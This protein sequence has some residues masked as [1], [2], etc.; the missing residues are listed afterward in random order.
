MRPE[1]LK[2]LLE[3]VAA[4]RVSP[5]GA[6]RRLAHWPYEDLGFSKVDHHRQERQGFPEVVYAPGKTAPQLVAIAR[7]LFRRSAA[8][9][10]TRVNALQV[11]AL[12]A[13]RLPVE[14]RVLA[15]SAL[16]QKK[17]A[18][19]PGQGRVLVL[20]AGTADIPVAEE[21]ALTAECLGAAV[22]KIFD[23][24]VAGLHRLLAHRRQMETARCIVAVAGME[25]AL[26]SVVGGLVSCPVIGVPASVGYGTAFG[27]VTPL[28][29][30]LNSCA[31]N[32]AVVNID[33]GFGA[34]FLAGLINRGGSR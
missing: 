11:K 15:Q 20:T 34:G 5:E 19:H 33:D 13:A 4:G 21:A 3:R 8:V 18:K 7:A 9:L 17:S 27:G 14:H 6:A 30:M 26:P 23:V 22:E 25:G 31:P 32:V 16:I 24:G 12:R 2:A 1:E 28:L 10:V 29:S